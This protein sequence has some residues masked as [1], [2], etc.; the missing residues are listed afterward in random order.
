MI[1]TK[2]HSCGDTPAD[3]ESACVDLAGEWHA[4][5]VKNMSTRLFAHCRDAARGLPGYIYVAERT[6]NDRDKRLGDRAMS[7]DWGRREATRYLQAWGAHE[8]V[9][10]DR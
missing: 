10:A 3:F 9:L 7:L 2:L 8:P 6:I 4:L 5:Q 1:K